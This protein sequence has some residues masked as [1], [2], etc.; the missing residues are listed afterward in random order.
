MAQQA[1]SAVGTDF[2][3]VADTF[4]DHVDQLDGA[5]GLL[6]NIAT[7]KGTITGDNAGAT[8]AALEGIEAAAKAAVSPDAMRAAL[9][10]ILREWAASTEVDSDAA[11][12][13]SQPVAFFSDLFDY[14]VDNSESVN[15]PADSY[16]TSAA[17]GGSNVGD[18][19]AVR[20]TVD[21]ND[22]TLWGLEPDTYT[23]RCVE[24]A[25]QTG[26]AHDETWEIYG[27]KRTGATARETARVRFKTL[28][29]APQQ[30][31]PLKNSGFDQGTGTTTITAMPGWR[32]NTDGASAVPSSN[33]QR[34][35][36]HTFG[37]SI[38]G[39]A[40]HYGVIFT[41]AETLYQD[42]VLEGNG[43]I[44]PDAPYLIGVRV[45]RTNSTT[46]NVVLRLSDTIGSGGR[47][48]TL[49]IS[50]VTNNQWTT[51]WLDSGTAGQ[52]C[53]SARWNANSLKL[54]IVG[55][56]DA[57]VDQ[58]IFNPM[59]RF[60]QETDQRRGRGSM[61]QYVAYVAGLTPAAYDDTHAW[62]GDSAGTKG[63]IIWA[64]RKAALGYLPTN[65]A[66]SETVADV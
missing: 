37:P 24:D 62:T 9:V 60:G 44:D 47:S 61:G 64:L 63:E 3:T 36:T 55:V 1:F 45:K 50:T 5:N 20:L 27:T 8:I 29:G 59:T 42:F 18:G 14:F 7:S 65:G 66:G 46:G 13:G 26:K 22:E 25:R 40:T 53:W 41:G 33:I 10:P 16:D 48:A 57:V 28:T 38:P 54:Q 39:T 21:E 17:A 34:T 2:A 31:S 56:T 49:D 6:A 51:L 12:P 15:A 11:T 30:G 19:T 23:I 43:R 52:E 35:T 4:V 58:V 32:T